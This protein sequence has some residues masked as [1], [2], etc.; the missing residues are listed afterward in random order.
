MAVNA[1]WSAL[2]GAG[3]ALA[4]TP[5]AAAA[6]R[7]TGMMDRPG[8]LKPQTRAVPYLGGVAVA[9]G[10]AVGVWLGDAA[11]LLLPPAAA[12]ALGLADDRFDLPIPARVAGEVAVGAGVALAAHAGHD[13][14]LWAVAVA[15]TVGAIN[16]VNLLDGL[17]GLASTVVGVAAIGYAILAAGQGRVLAASL[18]GALGGFLV[19]NWA[20]ARI[21]LGDAGSYLLG[22]VLASLL[23]LTWAANS[24]NAP[25]AL[26]LL[27]Y[28]FGELLCSVVR[29]W[30]AKRPL[31]QGDRDHTYDRLVKRGWRP[32][33][34]SM[35]CGSGQA[36]L[37][38][39]A[40][41][42]SVLPQAWA[43]AAA[44]G[45]GAVLAAGAFRAGLLTP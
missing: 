31:L 12:M 45:L 40:L 27:A 16:G 2:A 6:A 8:P 41:G 24:A 4:C 10:L 22:T 36:A 34:V 39:A 26:A 25:A 15:G 3:V 44:A 23:V 43:W 14:L 9:A 19:F 38:G 11:V 21:Y 13:L 32:G 18:A 20:P 28:P 35:L 42:L 37:V 17:D 1:L 7:R 30:R 29:R 33:P 5:I